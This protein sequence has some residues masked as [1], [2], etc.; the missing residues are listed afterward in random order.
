MSI[1]SFLSCTRNLICIV[2]C[3]HT[4]GYL[5][6]AVPSCYIQP[7]VV[8]ILCTYKDDPHPQPSSTTSA[9]EYPEPIGIKHTHTPHA[10][11]CPYP[12][13]ILTHSL[14]PPLTHTH[15][16]M[17]NLLAYRICTLC[18]NRAHARPEASPSTLPTKKAKVPICKG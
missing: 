16:S 6:A 10:I 2:P 14:S 1:A 12:I 4:V 9:S 5:H 17:N 15:A 8:V 18:T 11:M 3:P 13:C 7:W